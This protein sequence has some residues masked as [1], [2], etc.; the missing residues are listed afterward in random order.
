MNTEIRDRVLAA[1]DEQAVIDLEQA[2]VRIPS[3]TY[4]E[5]PLAEYLADYMRDAGIEVELHEVVDPFGSGRASKQ[6]VGIIRGDGS[7][8][9]LMFNGHMDHNPLAG[10]WTRD[11]YSGDIE[12]DWLHGRG[13]IDEKGGVTDL[14]IAGVAIK[15]SGLKLKGDL[16]LC[17]VMGHK[18]GAIGTLYLMQQGILADRVI[19][20][21]NTNLG[22]ATRGVGVVVAQITFLGRTVPRAAPPE[23]RAKLA[24]PIEKLAKFVMALGVPQRPMQPGEWMTFEPDPELPGFPRFNL[25]RLEHEWVPENYCRLNMQ[26]RLVPG[27]N[28]DTLRADL[29]RLVEGLRE[30]D[31]N[32]QVE[33]E[34]PPL[35][36]WNWPP[37]AVS[38]G[39]PF[40]ATLAKWHEHI[41]G[42]PPEISAQPRLGAV[43]DAGF[44][45]DAGI[46]VVQYGPGN[47][48]IFKQWPTPDERI[49]LPDLIAG[50]KIMALTA[51]E[52]CEAH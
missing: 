33:L 37:Y 32:L 16:L 4:E 46:P 35:G 22:I 38:E 24:N 1:I 17:P 25:D 2:I 10:T 11:P 43:G 13:S 27:Q 12:G 5:A 52:L 39:L 7:G 34:V 44:L 40:I 9:S 31:P 28:A 18:S 29:E 51:A 48:G 45:G 41:M 15:K 36:G 23:E 26:V 19:N 42:E 47:S 21:E 3:L 30:D 20:T 50:A 14:V 49:Y 8:P 6:P